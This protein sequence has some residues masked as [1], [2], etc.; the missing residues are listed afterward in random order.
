MFIWSPSI[1][2]IA[3]ID[4]LDGTV[5]TGINLTD[6]HLQRIYEDQTCMFVF[7]LENL[8]SLQFFFNAL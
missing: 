2:V 5:P 3:E 4:I 1:H 7:P 8:I 6:K